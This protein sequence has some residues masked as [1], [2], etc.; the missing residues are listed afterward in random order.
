MA[1]AVVGI[2]KHHGRHRFRRLNG[3]ATEVRRKLTIMATM[4]VI[5]LSLS[6]FF[7]F[8]TSLTATVFKLAYR[9]ALHC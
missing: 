5:F 6:I 8:C 1:T 7:L 9:Y 3:M 4:V 2:A